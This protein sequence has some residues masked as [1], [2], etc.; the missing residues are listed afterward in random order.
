MSMMDFMTDDYMNL[1]KVPNLSSIFYRNNT[2]RKTTIRDISDPIYDNSMHSL[3]IS[4]SKRNLSFIET[5]YYNRYRNLVDFSYNNFSNRYDNYRNINEISDKDDVKNMD[6][7]VQA[8]KLPKYSTTS[9]N[10]EIRS[11]CCRPAPYNLSKLLYINK[12]DIKT[13]RHLSDNLDVLRYTIPALEKY[14]N[15]DRDS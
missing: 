11:M 2:T 7:L 8:S 5:H 4:H 12:E 15:M 3:S 1:G 13:M 6:I 9:N 14:K 10:Y